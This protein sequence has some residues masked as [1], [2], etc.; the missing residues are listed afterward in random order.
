MKKVKSTKSVWPPED[1]Q[2]YIAGAVSAYKMERDWQEVL[3]MLG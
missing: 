3:D 2:E 1:L